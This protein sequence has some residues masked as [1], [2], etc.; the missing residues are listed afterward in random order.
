MTFKELS[1]FL[2]RLE[3]TSSRI[4]ITKILAELFAKA[5]AEEIDKATYLLLGKLAPNYKGIVFNL[6]DRMMARIIAK[7]FNKETA[8]V[9]RLY[10]AKGD[11]GSVAEELAAGQGKNLS[12]NEVYESLLE[13]AKDSGEESQERKVNKTAKLLSE[14]DPQSGKFVT[15]I[16]LGRL[17]LGFSDK[18]ILDAL[19]WMEKGDKSGKALLEKAYE[20]LPDVGLLAKEVK[21]KG[22]TKASKNITPKIGVPVMPMLAQRLKSPREMVEKMGKVAIEPKFDGLR[23][24]V[25]FRKKDGG[26]I[27]DLEKT[28]TNVGD[29][30]SSDM[31]SSFRRGK[32][33]HKSAED[34]I[35]TF[36]RNMNE[37]SWMFPELAKAGDYIK[38]DE[39]I[40]DAEAVGL[41]ETRKTLATFQTTMTRRRKHEIEKI[42]AQ[43]PIKF[44]V[45]DILYKN[46]DSLIDKSYPERRKV[47]EAT[48]KNGHL[49]EIVD[50]QV[51]ENPEEI[52]IQNT[53]RRKAGFEGIIVKKLESGY[54]PGRTGWRWVKMKEAEEAIGK[55]ADTVDA[56]VMGYTG[57]KGKRAA[58]GLGQFLVGII[59]GEKIKT[60]T[61][62]GTGLTDIQFKE[63]KK[64]LSG[65]TVKTMPKNYEVNKI[66]EPD[67]WVMPEVVVELAAD[68]ITKS[69]NHTSGYALRFPR[70]VKFR[71]DKSPK[72]ATTLKEIKALYEIQKGS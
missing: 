24:S 51:T 56:V 41:D 66:L 54:V 58:F 9:V 26:F 61:K 29:K 16:P 7:A 8:D 60:V 47:L 55:L 5:G 32:R 18:T 62:V 71:D 69:P 70:L 28:Q 14:L 6:A 35:K 59:D 68:E 13:I 11:L 30:S 38:G 34:V 1:E 46:G 10:K 65:L 52:T 36:T 4:E 23:I 45:F 2:N 15:R 39:V 17:R 25:H 67:F 31:S 40:L 49:F 57:G 50:Y 37:T 20:V 44:Y 12:V 33:G 53:Q 72:E 64:R 21:L 42:S 3:K 43:I 22:I 27:T 63:L 48:V 19:S